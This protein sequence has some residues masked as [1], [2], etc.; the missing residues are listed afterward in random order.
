MST[1]Y[2]RLIAKISGSNKHPLLLQRRITFLMWAPL[3]NWMAVMLYAVK[4]RE[5]RWGFEPKMLKK[6]SVWFVSLLST[7]I[8]KV[9]HDSLSLAI[10]HEEEYEYFFVQPESNAMDS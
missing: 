9:L 4:V 2:A 10:A 1:M 8:Y 6:P 5:T 3:L 7:L